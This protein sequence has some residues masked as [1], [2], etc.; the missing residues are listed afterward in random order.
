MVPFGWQMKCHPQ[1]DN[2]RK[3]PPDFTATPGLT[4]PALSSGILSMLL[5]PPQAGLVTRLGG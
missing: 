1:R 3:V 5:V 2:V 4:G